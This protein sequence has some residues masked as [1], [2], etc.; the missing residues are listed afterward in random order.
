M[1]LEARIQDG[2][3][4]NLKI[5]LRL[6]SCSTQV[7]QKIRQRLREGF[8]TTLPR[9][10]YL[11]QLERHPDGLSMSQLSRYLMVTC[12]NVIGLT[13]QLVNERLVDRLSCPDDK[14]SYL[15]KLTHKGRREFIAMAAAH[16]QWLAE[17][18][19]ALPKAD[20]LELY[21]TLGQMR[22]HLTKCALS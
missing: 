5:W 4:L 1:G 21:Q 22:I 9:F 13:D 11:A 10:D 3:H 16:E 7:E 19:C 17:L 14:R 15:V 12:G 2:G 18:F 6:L 20:K 8:G